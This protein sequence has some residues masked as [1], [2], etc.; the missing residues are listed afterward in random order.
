ML[1][2][3]TNMMTHRGPD[4]DGY[5]L[6]PGIRLGLRRLSIIDLQ[7]GDQPI[8]YEDG[9]VTVVCNGD[10]YN[11]L[12]LRRHLQAAGHRFRTNSDVEVLVSTKPGIRRSRQDGL[13]SIHT[14]HR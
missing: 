1:H 3:M 12:E 10:I 11:Y 2:R 13:R 4:G 7:T 6:E 9:A 5:F 8:S 14:D